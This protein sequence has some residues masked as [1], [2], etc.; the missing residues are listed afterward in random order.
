PHG[1]REGGPSGAFRTG[2]GRFRPCA[3]GALLAILAPL[4]GGLGVIRVGPSHMPQALPSDALGV[5]TPQNGGARGHGV[6][7]SIAWTVLLATRQT[8]T[9]PAS[10]RSAAPCS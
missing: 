4:R 3:L 9:V 6:E 2:G 1:D 8:S 7:V 10:A 5:F